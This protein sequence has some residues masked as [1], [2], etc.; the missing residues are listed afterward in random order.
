[1]TKR[2]KGL[3]WAKIKNE[4]ISTDISQREIAKKYGI[5]PST[6]AR[7]A[8]KESWFAD[9]EKFESETRAKIAQKLSDSV[10]KNEVDR[11]TR[12]L[13]LSDLLSDKIEKAINELDIYIAKNKVKTKVV[14]YTED[15]K[16]KPAKEVIEEK[17]VISEVHSIVNTLALSQIANALKAIKEIT[18]DFSGKDEEVEDSG[19]IEA[20]TQRSED[21][22]KNGDDSDMLPQID[23][24]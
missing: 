18:A 10:A 7:R 1:M 11:L 6:V 3:D 20:L 4:Y 5:A 16:G 12:V 21:L 8:K 15:E 17:E 2:K 13:G 19:L 22:F 9:R 24:G 23:E 14:E